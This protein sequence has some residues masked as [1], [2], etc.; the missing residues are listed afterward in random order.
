MHDN[1]CEIEIWDWNEDTQIEFALPAG[2]QKNHAE[3]QRNTQ[4]R[5]PNFV[6]DDSISS[7]T[8]RE[9]DELSQLNENETLLE[10]EIL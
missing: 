7:T 6:A 5:E 1:I 9:D 10:G 2:Y 3:F 4:Q 8:T